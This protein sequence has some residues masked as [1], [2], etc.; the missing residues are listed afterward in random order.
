MP[1]EQ[2][3]IDFFMHVENIAFNNFF[4]DLM[5]PIKVF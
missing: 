3:D 1:I 4:Y 5:S 2:R